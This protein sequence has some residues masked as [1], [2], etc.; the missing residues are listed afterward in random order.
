VSVLDRL[1]GY[2]KVIVMLAI[3]AALTGLVIAKLITGPEYTETLKFISA[4]FMAAN[5]GENLL[6]K[7]KEKE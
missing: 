2:R 4:A 7:T 1:I 5:L 6:I 3:L